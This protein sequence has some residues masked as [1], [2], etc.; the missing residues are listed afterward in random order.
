MSNILSPVISSE[1]FGMTKI[2]LKLLWDGPDI[3]SSKTYRLYREMNSWLRTSGV[4][5]KFFWEDTGRYLPDALYLD[6]KSDTATCFVLKYGT[7]K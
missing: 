4:A 3:L 1:F 2:D 7:C 5:Y 6:A